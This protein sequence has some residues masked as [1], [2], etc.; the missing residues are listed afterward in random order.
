MRQTRLP[1]TAGFRPGSP[2]RFDWAWHRGLVCIGKSSRCMRLIVVSSITPIPSL[3]ADDGLAALVHGDALDHDLLRALTAMAVQSFQERRIA[4]GELG[5]L[6]EVLAPPLEGLVRDHGA[7]HALHASVVEADEL[8]DQHA[9]QLV[10]R[11]DADHG[12]EGGLDLT[13][14]EIGRA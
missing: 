14:S 6:V 10:P 7:A 12:A 1:L 13:L 9:L 8:T 4:A 5:C 2:V 11:T 3:D